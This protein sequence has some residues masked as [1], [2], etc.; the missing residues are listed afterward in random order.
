LKNENGLVTTHKSS[1][2]KSIIKMKGR[3]EV[4]KNSA[5]R[6]EGN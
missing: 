5:A 1:E 3:G 4:G 2:D 6:G